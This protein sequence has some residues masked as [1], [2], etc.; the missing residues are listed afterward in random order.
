MAKYNAKNSF[1]KLKNLTIERAKYRAQA[2]ASELGETPKNVKNFNFT[3]KTMYGR[4]DLNYDTVFMKDEFLKAISQG[5]DTFFVHNPVA[6]SFRLFRKR[7]QDATAQ[8]H[9][10]KDDP[11]LTDVKI[12][13]AFE[14]PVDLYISYMNEQIRIF[15]DQVDVDLVSNYSDWCNQFVLFCQK[16]GPQ[17]PIS[18]SGFQRTKRSN[19]FTS[20]LVISIAD[21]DYHN[22]EQK[23]KFFLENN[24]LEFYTKTAM[25]F[26]F[27]VNKNCPWLLIYDLDSPANKLYQRSLGLSTVNEI[28]SKT[29]YL[30]HKYDMTYLKFLLSEG[31]STFAGQN[32]IIKKPK[33]ICNKTYF[34]ISFRSNDINNIIY[35][36]KYYINL[37]I[38]LKNIEEYNYLDAAELRRVIQKAIIFEEKLDISYSIDYINEQYKDS[39]ST[40]PGSLHN[41]IIEQNKASEG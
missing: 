4:I 40:R 24:T 18:F 3:D 6:E 26:G 23:S 11:Y 17:Y 7:M 33:I 9:I 12:Y 38:K 29:Y 13:R 32:R 39:Y 31:Y 36:N 22:D 14:D 41:L 34:N 25:E 28:F 1:K 37:Y 19:M 30:C 5:Q 21:L 2:F 27:Y 10:P 8:L 15:N 20:G 35:N 16:G